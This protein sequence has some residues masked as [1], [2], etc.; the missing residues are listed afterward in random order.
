M[1]ASS[2]CCH[3]SWLV[4]AIIEAGFVHNHKQTQIMLTKMNLK[5]CVEGMH[6]CTHA[7]TQS[8]YTGSYLHLRI[9]SCKHKQCSAKLLALVTELHAATVTKFYFISHLL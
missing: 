8:I 9:C 5:A 1:Y 7:H 4:V 3:T 6:T 2:K